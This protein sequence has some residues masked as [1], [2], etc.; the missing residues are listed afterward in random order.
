MLKLPSSMDDIEALA[1]VLPP[2][3]K[4]ILQILDLLRDEESSVEVLAR[5]VRNDPV[6]S[7]NVLGMANHIRRLHAQ[8]DLTDIFAA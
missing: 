7:G 4:G 1:S 2:F 3:P 6:L 8:S 5:L